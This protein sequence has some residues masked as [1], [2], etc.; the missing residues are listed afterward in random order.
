M[1][2]FRRLSPTWQFKQ[3]LNSKKKRKEKSKEKCGVLAM[4]HL[5]L[6][7]LRNMLLSH[8]PISHSPIPKPLNLIDEN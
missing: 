8:M 7:N 5:Y 4:D 3:S 6:N 2:E 1:L